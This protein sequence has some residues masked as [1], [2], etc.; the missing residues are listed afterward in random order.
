MPTI[1]KVQVAQ[2]PKG[3]PALI[4]D[5]ARKWTEHVNLAKD[6]KAALGD[7]PKGYFEATLKTDGGGRYWLIGKRV[8]D[9]PW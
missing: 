7:D 4:Y 3:A 8:S 9:Q 6:T 1:V 5:K 2:F